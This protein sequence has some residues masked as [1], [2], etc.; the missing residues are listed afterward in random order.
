MQRPSGKHEFQHQNID[1]GQTVSDFLARQITQQK[2][3]F[4][5]QWSFVLDRGYGIFALREFETLV[6][7]EVVTRRGRLP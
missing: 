5:I 6:F 1:Y 2:I 4:S 7:N 3:I